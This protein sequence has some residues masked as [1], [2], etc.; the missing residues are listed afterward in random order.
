MNKKL[1]ALAVA[2]AL[3]P[4]AAMADSGNV[5]VYGVV[6]ASVDR[7]D[8][9]TAP[10]NAATPFNPVTGA[11][12]TPG[13]TNFN[14]TGYRV[15]SNSSRIGF[16]GTEDLGNGLAAVWQMETGVNLDSGTN[17]GSYFQRNSFLGLSSKTAGTVLFGRH[18]TPYKLGT[19]GLDLFADT[20]G[21]YNAIVG[22]IGGTVAFDSR[23]GN[24]AAYISP[25]WGGF[26]FAGA[27]VAANETNNTANRDGS[28]YSLTGIYDNGPMFGS[29][30][31]ERAKDFSA[32]S[33]DVTSLASTL[34][35]LDK[36]TAAKLGLG[37]KF[38]GATVGFIAER[39]KLVP[40]L[41]GADLT[42]NAYYLNGSYTMGSNVLKAAYGQANDMSGVSDSGA[43]QYVI[44]VDH[45][46][47]KRTSVY[48]LY[49]KMN[50]DTVGSYGLGGNGAG[51]AFAPAAA[52]QDPSVWSA[53]MR[54]SF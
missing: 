22:N 31:Y 30:S 15:S 38:G 8:P 53:G 34:S 14:D 51:G 45:N 29:L 48:A 35:T 37:Y 13:N 12:A 24:V 2:A 16:K 9:G 3:A 23:L 41:T 50:N 5:T 4:A 39:I 1:I 7:A 25:T 33:T 21:D 44:G 43:K 6:H 17:G 11:A 46:F 27:A 18:D 26:H 40:T 36:A 47:S 28:A 20:M 54:H 49:S 10:S 32:S 52:G 19:G 42:R